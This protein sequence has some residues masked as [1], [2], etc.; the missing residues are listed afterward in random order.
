MLAHSHSAA[1]LY[2]LSQSAIKLHRVRHLTCE[3]AWFLPRVIQVF[4]LCL[5][6]CHFAR[7]WLQNYIDFILILEL[8][9]FFSRY[10]TFEIIP[11]CL[12]TWKFILICG[13]LF[14]AGLA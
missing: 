12:S 5:P 14:K 8:A 11:K 13:R 2:N 10:S 1:S 7:F 6:F 9:V 4:I 3:R